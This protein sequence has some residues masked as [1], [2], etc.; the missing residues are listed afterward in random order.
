[1]EI[2]HAR[3]VVRHFVSGWT[4]QKLC[5][6]LA[7][8]ED[9]K[10][11]AMNVCQCLLGVAS[12]D[13]LHESKDCPKPHH[14]VRYGDD[15]NARNT[16]LAYYSLDEA[17]GCLTNYNGVQLLIDREFIAILRQVLAEREALNSAIHE[18]KEFAVSGNSVSYT[19]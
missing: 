17:G 7:F 2:T 13:Q 9:G 12:S 1:M 14:F 4:T 11:D 19:Q 16:E 6:V 10:M 5:E 3:Q 8:A 18:P 15:Y